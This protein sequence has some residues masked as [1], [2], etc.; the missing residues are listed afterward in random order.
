[1]EIDYDALGRTTAL[2]GPGEPRSGGTPTATVAYD[3]SASAA[4]KTTMRKLLSGTGTSAKYVTSYSYDDG[5]GRTRET[6][7][8]SPA[9]G[10]IV[11]ATV[12]DGR[13]LTRAATQPAYN[14]GAP[15]SGL[16][17]PVLATL[18]QWT[19]TLYDTL[20][21]PTAVIERSLAAELRRT[22]TAYPGAD[23][24]EVTPPVGGKTATVMDAAGRTVK[25]EEW[26][27]TVVHH[28]TAYGYNVSGQLA[29]VTDASGN[30]R[31]FTYD[32]LDRRTATTDPDAGTSTN[33]YDAMGRA[34]WGIDGNGSKIS[35]SY[36]DLGRRTAQWV[37]EVSTGTKAAEWTYDT[38]AKGQP[39]SA[40]RYVGVNAYTDT[41]TGYDDSYRP[42]GTKLTIPTA[43][44]ALAGDYAFTAAYDRAGNPIE[45]AMPAAG[46]L[47]AE[48]LALSYTDLGLP[49]ALT[50]NYGGGATYV[51]DTLYSQTARL[52]ERHYGA[53]AQ[54]KRS[55]TWDTVTG[56]LSRLTTTAKADTA[57]PQIAQDDQVT[58]NSAGDITR[59][60][61]AASAIPGTTPGQSECFTYDGLT[62]LSAA[63]TTTASSCAT[64]PA[65]GGIDPYNHSYTYDAVGNLTNLTDGTATATYT[66]PLRARRRCGPTRSPPSPAPAAPTPTAT[67]TPVS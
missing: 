12:Y 66:Y 11:A 15:G 26:K 46:G 52:S 64:G 44:G 6:Q 30:V 10:R 40:T 27:D 22:T 5:L 1:M 61:D 48:T 51:K 43:E 21:R 19:E 49:K 37:G 57:T 59:I 3:V 47:A 50:S 63:F 67:T 20:Q 54:V 34:L 4:A 28:D 2:W 53:N 9:G 14:A 17:N 45:Q 36:D 55:F 62:R 13:G 33:G 7:V 41:V 38:L 32:W 65:T 8:A 39:T 58:Y 23:R 16:L 31:T 29:K 24:V 42:T 25:T 60:L 56:W 18:P 35:Y